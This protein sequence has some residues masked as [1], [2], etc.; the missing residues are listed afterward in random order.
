[1]RASSPAQPLAV[2]D[3]VWDELLAGHVGVGSASQRLNDG[4]GYIYGIQADYARRTVY[5]YSDTLVN[6]TTYVPAAGTLVMVASMVSGAAGKLELM[7]AAQRIKITPTA[8]ENGFTGPIYCDGTRIGFKNVEGNDR[9]LELD[10]I[11]I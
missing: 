3:A 11:T 8:T 6:N 2:A 10:G 4:F 1:M 9:N 5:A 7:T